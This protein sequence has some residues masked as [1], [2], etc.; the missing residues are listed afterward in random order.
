MP[1]DPTLARC[2]AV[3]L[4]SRAARGRIGEA[5]HA[6]VTIIGQ[7]RK[8]TRS[9]VAKDAERRDE[10][11]LRE[12]TGLW[13]CAAGAAAD[14]VQEFVDGEFF[15]P[16][17]PGERNGDKLVELL[18]RA[19]NGGSPCLENGGPQ[20]PEWAERR[21]RRRIAL[22]QNAMLTASGR[23]SLIR[24]VDLSASGMGL[25]GVP[26]LAIGTIVR[27]RM[28]TQRCFIGEV[29]WCSDARA[30]IQFSRELPATDPLLAGE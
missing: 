30:G 19:Q 2:H 3:A 27:I 14:F 23:T 10:A 16:A 13:R 24:V 20:L 21:R 22:N 28:S 12:C 15:L 9:L 1:P 11:S 4:C 17:G 8:V 25:A 7:A 29:V 18:R 6:L 5:V 26:A